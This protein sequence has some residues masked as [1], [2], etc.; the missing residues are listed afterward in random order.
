MKKWVR[1]NYTIESTFLLCKIDYYVYP[2]SYHGKMYTVRLERS[3]D[4][5][6]GSIYSYKEDAKHHRGKKLYFTDIPCI[7][8]DNSIFIDEKIEV[9][10]YLDEE[11]ILTYLPQFVKVL[12]ELYREQLKKEKKKEKKKEISANWNGK[13]D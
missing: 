3:L 12:F 7:I 1:K 13:L 8:R 6:Y 11:D 4:A 10:L 9:S 5:L 2:I